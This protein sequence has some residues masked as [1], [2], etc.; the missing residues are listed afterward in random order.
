[1]QQEEEFFEV[2]T[3]K[4]KINDEFKLD[5]KEEYF[6]ECGLELASDNERDLSRSMLNG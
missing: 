5:A 6:D 1:M 4:N 3:T 2:D